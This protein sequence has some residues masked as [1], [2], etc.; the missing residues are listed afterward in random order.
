MAIR[1]SSVKP[2]PT[3]KAR[4]TKKAMPKRATS[5][6][7]GPGSFEALQRDYVAELR[8]EIPKVKKWWNAGLKKDQTRSY[9]GGIDAD[10]ATRWP[11]EM[12]GHPRLIAIFRKYFLLVE[13]LNADCGGEVRPIDLLV[14][15]LEEDHDDLHEVMTSMLFIPIGM[16]EAGEAH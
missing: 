16:N 15:D 8:K 11:T 5:S 4:S 1:A 7:K 10:F 12:G 13:K 14:N 9:P 6:K 3:A 2:K